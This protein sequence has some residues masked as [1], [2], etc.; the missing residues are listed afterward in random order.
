TGNECYCGDTYD[1]N[2]KRDDRCLKRCENNSSVSETCGG[3]WR[4]QMYSVCPTGKYKGAGD[5]LIGNE[6]NC[7]NECHCKALPCFYL[8]GTCTD[9][10]AIGWKGD[11]CNERDC[12]VA[13]GGCQQQCTEKESEKWCSCDMK[14]RIPPDDW[15]K[16]VEIVKCVGVRGA[17]YHEDCH[18]CV[19]TNGS[20]TC[21]CR[22]GYELDPST[23]Q[24]CID[25]DEC[26]GTRGVD[27]DQDCHRC[28]NTIGSYTCTCDEDYRL[29]P[30]T[31]TQCMPIGKTDTPERE[32]SPSGVCVGV[33]VK[34]KQ[35]PIAGGTK[36]TVVG[37]CVPLGLILGQV[38]LRSSLD[39]RVF[40]TPEVDVPQSVPI[41]VILPP[42]SKL[43][44]LGSE[45]LYKA[46][47]VIED[48][49]PKALSSQG[50]TTMTVIGSN[51]DTV[52]N[53]R[54]NITQLSITV[55]STDGTKT[56]DQVDY[57][58][59]PCIV[60]TRS[61]LACKTPALKLPSTEEFGNFSAEFVFGF[62]FDG[63]DEYSELREERHNISAAEF[64]VIK[65]PDVHEHHW[66]PYDSSA[67]EPLTLQISWGDFQGET[68]VIVGGVKSDIAKR[69]TS[70]ISFL[71]PEEHHIKKNQ[72][73]DCH[74][75]PDA[76]TVH[77]Q[78]GNVKGIAGCLKYVP[79]K[80]TTV[81]IIG[82]TA[83]VFC[84]LLVLIVACVVHKKKVL[85]RNRTK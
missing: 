70:S 55:N 4:L 13:N 19:N 56:F 48:L 74:A 23:K 77:V 12:K 59:T 66:P 63:Y 2:A 50:G 44:T 29:N 3:D 39:S 64:T 79:S 71:P 85:K 60:Q 32:T 37:Q 83:A 75:S 82:V 8:N 18:T 6:T 78:A 14:F 1:R 81:I 31:N 47:P 21:V 52:A 22:N 58:L 53:S 17:D 16:C 68:D 46:N 10:C 33:D 35:G 11:A 73:S 72:K 28:V 34:P 43:H 30:G 24:K 42:E 65:L 80:S 9:G 5:A 69:Y 20:Y 15:R 84:L 26:E 49:T 57:P 45:F 40:E 36:V 7:E 76:H 38:R 25:I 54:L 41:Y 62:E 51:L 67:N 27:Y 61:L